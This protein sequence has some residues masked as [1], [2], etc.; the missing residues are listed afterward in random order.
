[1]AIKQDNLTSKFSGW[2]IVA[3]LLMLI[4]LLSP[5]LA[6]FLA[7]A[8][9][10]YICNPMVDSIETWSLGKLRFGRT[11]ASS[12]VTLVVI[13][14]VLLLLLIVLPLLQKELMMAIERLSFY[15]VHLK[16]NLEPWLMQNFGIA[17]EFNIENLQSILSENWKSAGGL[18]GNMLLTLSSHGMTIIAWLLNLLLVPLVL[19]YFLR[20]WHPLL[21]AIG[22]LVPRKM[23]VTTQKIATEIDAVLAEFL[24][25]QLTVMLLMSVFYTIGLKLAG[26]DLALPIGILAGALGFVPYLGIG[27]GILLA[28]ISGLLEFST[29]S[30]F[31]P[32]VAVFCLG[33]LLESMWLTPNLVGDRIGLH[34]VAVIF[35]LLAGGQLFGFTGVLLALPASAAIAVTL[36]HL[37]RSYFDGDLYQ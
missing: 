9:L 16:R 31:T 18:M 24:R 11:T 25:G 20:D 23:F 26:L 6:P 5:I 15:T 17:L 13:T 29:L 21:A 33:Q 8:I 4:Y 37:R 3:T 12:I 7:A 14:A 28:T 35:S 2:M 10:A 32:V 27:L 34:P 22:E 19:F 1:M 30:Q 36:R